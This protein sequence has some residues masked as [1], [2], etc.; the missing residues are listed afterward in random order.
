M[1]DTVK[2]GNLEQSAYLL[3][4][5]APIRK[6]DTSDNEHRISAL[7]DEGYDDN[8]KSSGYKRYNKV[9]KV[10][11]GV[12]LRYYSLKEY[13]KLPEDQIEEL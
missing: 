9:D 5:A 11:F 3:L 6:N 10:S 2:R 4:L 1:G 13:N 7:N 8:K 12:E